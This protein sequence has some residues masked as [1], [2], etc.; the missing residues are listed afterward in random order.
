MSTRIGTPG[1]RIDQLQAKQKLL[2]Q[3]QKKLE[4]AKIKVQSLKKQVDSF[5]DVGGTFKKLEDLR[6]KRDAAFKA[7]ETSKSKLPGEDDLAYQTRMKTQENLKKMRGATDAELDHQQYSKEYEDLKKQFDNTSQLQ[8][9]LR[10]AKLAK[11]EAKKEFDVAAKD[12]K[13]AIKGAAPVV[14][15]G[16]RAQLAGA[17]KEASKVGRD[18]DRLESKLHKVSVEDQHK[19]IHRKDHKG[20]TKTQRIQLA[21]KVTTIY[22]TES[23]KVQY[24]KD[25]DEH[26]KLRDEERAAKADADRTRGA[27]NTGKWK[28]DE[29]AELKLAKKKAKE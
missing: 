7:I 24:Q 25:L 1:S 11:K 13:S 14:K 12:M 6:T 9:Q 23:E 10:Q 4:T 8:D 2:T 3:K 21:P 17:E 15:A 22:R 5:E 18:A 28:K 29:L 20:K 16:Q 19:D 26:R 27:L